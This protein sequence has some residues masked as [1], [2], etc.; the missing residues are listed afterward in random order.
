LIQGDRFLSATTISPRKEAMIGWITPLLGRLVQEQ[1]FSLPGDIG[2]GSRVLIVD[3]GDLTELLFFAPVINHLKNRFPGMRMTVLVREGNSELIRTM[4]QISEMISYEPEHLSLWSTTYYTLAKRLKSREFN[5]T[6]LLGRDF[7]FARSLLALWTRARLRVGYDHEFT[8]PFVNCELR[9]GEASLYE[10]QRAIAYL[11][12]LGFHAG[13]SL[14][15]WRLPAHDVRWAQQMIHF[16]KPDPDEKLIAV[17]PGVGKGNHRLAERSFSQ[18][19]NQIAS[20]YGSKVLVVSNNLDSKALERFKESLSV[21]LVDLTPKNV[22]EALALLS[23]AD[24]LLAGNTDFFHFSVGMRLPSIGFFTRHDEPNWFP[25]NTPWVQIIQG[26]K[27][28]KMSLDEVY[29]KIETLLHL[30]GELK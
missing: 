5:V 27:G 3:S 11:T 12:A 22:K 30:T 16:R 24:L 17:D 18:I 29:S 14:P 25:K 28:Q 6:F 23:R 13:D 26:V 19:V 2:N 4:D 9:R 7:S 1:T 20:R 10:A 15:G 8:Y 21:D